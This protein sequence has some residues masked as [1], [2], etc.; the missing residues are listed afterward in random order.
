MA[1]RKSSLVSDNYHFTSHNPTGN[2]SA[3]YHTVYTVHALTSSRGNCAS[4]AIIANVRFLSLEG[5][6][7]V[8]YGN[9]QNN[10]HMKKQRVT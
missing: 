5:L 9:K 7:N 8:N 2:T 4:L 3:A 6:L 10:S 1:S